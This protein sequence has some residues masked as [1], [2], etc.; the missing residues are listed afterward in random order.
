MHTKE[1]LKE[2]SEK[3]FQALRDRNFNAIPYSDDVIFRAPVVPG[4]SGNPLKGKKEVF[5]KW[6]TPL[7]PA[8]D[9]VEIKVV[10]HYYDE[11]LTQIMT[12]VEFWIPVLG[13][14]LRGVDQFVINANGEIE[15]QENHFDASPMKSHI[16]HLCLRSMNFAVTKKF[17]GDI[18]DWKLVMDTPDLIIYLTGSV[19]VAFKK[20]DPRDKQYSTFSPFEV[21]LDHIAITCETEEELQEFAKKIVAAGVENTGVKMDEVLNKLY[22]AFKD[23]DRIAWEF[24]MK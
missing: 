24:Y 9:G 23:P 4:G 12:K 8:L 1:K 6:W 19:F 7:Q 13:A 11:T 10:D 20:A 22:I 16:H 14:K 17:Y 21:G 5:E 15:K 3:F 18:L 2:I